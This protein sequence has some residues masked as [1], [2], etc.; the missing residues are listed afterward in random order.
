MPEPQHTH[1]PNADINAANASRRPRQRGRGED[2]QALVEFALVL[3]LLLMVVTAIMQF[4]SMYNQYITITDAVRTGVRTLALSRTLDDPCD[5]AV[6]QTLNSAIGTSLTAG[7]VTTTLVSPDTCGS[8]SYPNR[9]GGSEAPGDEATVSASCPY[10]FS[11]FGL[12]LFNVQLSASA[13]E[14]IE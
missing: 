1:R 7:E 2:G 6:T 14:S 10:S 5:R 12:P 4:G 8:G 3:P 11:V 9:T 13:A